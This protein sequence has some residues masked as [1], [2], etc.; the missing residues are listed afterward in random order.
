MSEEENE[1][2]ESMDEER[3]KLDEM[4]LNSTWNILTNEKRQ[5]KQ[6]ED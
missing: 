4:G 2:K 5:K 1:G 3:K 6:S